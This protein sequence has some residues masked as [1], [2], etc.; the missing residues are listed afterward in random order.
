MQRIKKQRYKKWQK[1]KIKQLFIVVVIFCCIFSFVVTFGKYIS[2]NVYDFFLKSKEFYFNS[3]KL[4]EDTAVFE[5]DNWSGVDDYVI[6][7]NMNSIENNLKSASYDI[8]YDI[9]YK[10]SSNAICQLSKTSGIINASS[11]SDSFNLTITPNTQLNDGDKV[12][13]EI[14][15]KSTAKYKK[16]LKGKFTFVV[17]KENLTYQIVD[18]NQSP[19]MELAFTNTLTYYT[20][21]EPFSN[22]SVGENIDSD[23]YLTLSDSDKAKCYSAIVSIEF[24]PKDILLDMTDEVYL[25][26]SDR[27]NQNINGK[28][29]ISGFTIEIAPCSSTNIRFYKSNVSEDYS[30]PNKDNKSIVKVTNY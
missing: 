7:V 25:K 16:T 3:D 17:G 20:V 21:K 29:Y 18:S 4:S 27:K 26:S 12:E 6:T 2:N 24:D 23:T 19:Y 15:T 13:V 14:E 10:C 5:I 11:N 8:G 30:Y 28:N 22:Y 1:F 9:S